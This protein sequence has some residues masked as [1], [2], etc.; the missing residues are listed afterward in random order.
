[1]GKRAVDNQSAISRMPHAVPLRFGLLP[2]LLEYPVSMRARSGTG[3]D[4]LVG[5]EIR[6]L[7]KA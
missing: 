1:M 7:L 6:R 5:L 3:I 2:G 4:Q